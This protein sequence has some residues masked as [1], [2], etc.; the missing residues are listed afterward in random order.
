MRRAVRSVL[1]RRSSVHV[2]SQKD[3]AAAAKHLGLEP[4]SA[5]KKPLRVYSQ[6]RETPKA[7][8][9]YLW[10]ATD[11][12]V[13]FRG[14]FLTSGSP[15][16]LDLW[17]GTFHRLAQY[18]SRHQRVVLPLTL[19]PHETSVLRFTK[20]AAPRHVVRT[21]AD[22]VVVVSRRKVEIQDS[23]GGLQVLTTDS[24]RSKAVRLPRVDDPPL[25]V[26]E[27]TSGHLW[28]LQATTYGPEGIIE[29][30]AIALPGLT[31]WRTIPGLSQESGIGT[32]TAE[33][34][35]PTTWVNSRRGTK[36]NLGAFEGS[37]QVFVNGRLITKDIDPQS[38]LDVT[39]ALKAGTNTIKVVLATTPFN[40]A[41][42]TAPNTELTR[43]A[44]ATA[45]PKGTEAYGLLGPV[46][47]EPYARRT[48]RLR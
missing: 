42:A 4:A 36:L 21:S 1:A 8:Y 5:W 41:L 12:P 37:I 40:K 30:P 47:L 15:S 13:R 28:Q 33:V 22:S 20:H 17:N 6:L 34:T 31:D 35:V 25:T 44:W 2:R 38:A 10:N 3:I 29:R 26:G 45:L 46:R 23:Q 18:R 14:S 24:G 16:R 43:P 19:A 7:T 32:Y 39:R 11:Q 48:V 27:P 9:Y